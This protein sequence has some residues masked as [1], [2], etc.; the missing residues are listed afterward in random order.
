MKWRI[1]PPS[2]F[3]K[4]Y[5]KKKKKKRFEIAYTELIHHKTTKQYI[6]MHIEI[7]FKGI[8]TQHSN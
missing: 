1:P 7:I 4:I 8:K 3:Q 6:N 5:N 2:F